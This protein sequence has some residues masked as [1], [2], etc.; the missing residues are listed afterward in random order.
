MT[1]FFTQFH[2]LSRNVLLSR[3]SD[4]FNPTS[5][6]IS[7]SGYR[8]VNSGCND[9]AVGALGDEHREKRGAGAECDQSDG[10]V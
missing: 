4:P 1:N 10:R 3:P 7:G 6:D 8:D 2:T 5:I 9:A